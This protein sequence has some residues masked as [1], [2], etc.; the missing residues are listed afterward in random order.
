MPLTDAQIKALQP[1]L[2]RYLITDGRGLSLDVLPSGLKSWMYRYRQDG[3]YAKVTLGRYPD[4]T[5]KAARDKR[6]ELAAQ[7]VTGRSPAE[8]KKARREGRGGN[9]TVRDF[10]DRYYRE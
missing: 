1:R 3:V 8:E 7:V 5:L 2:A 9:P 6:D 10:G 4:L